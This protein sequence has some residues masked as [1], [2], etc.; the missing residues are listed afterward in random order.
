M[1]E[2]FKKTLPIYTDLVRNHKFTIWFVGDVQGEERDM[3]YYSFVQDKKR[4]N[5]DLKSIYPTIGGTADNIRRL[6]MQRLNVGFSRA[7][8]IMVFVHSMPLA[9]YSDTRLGNALRHYE[10]FRDA[11]RDHFIEDDSRVRFPAEEFF[12]GSSPRP[13][14]V[15]KNG[16]SSDLSPSLRWQVHPRSIAPEHSLGTGW[17]PDDRIRGRQGDVPDPRIRRGEIPY[18]KSGHRDPIQF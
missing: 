7:K 6:K 3:V 13:A 1:E 8:D 18:Q 4:D 11:T 15:R 14:F 12:T 16:R 10:K 2:L 5:A 9:D 17:F